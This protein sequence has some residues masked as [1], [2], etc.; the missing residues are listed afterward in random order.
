LLAAADWQRFAAAVPVAQLFLQ[1]WTDLLD[2]DFHQLPGFN[3]NWEAQDDIDADSALQ[4]TAALLLQFDGDAHPS[5]AEQCS[6]YTLR[7]RFLA[8][9]SV[10]I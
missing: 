2:I 8:F 10:S 6:L 1:L 4:A 9:R 7:V 5:L 3:P